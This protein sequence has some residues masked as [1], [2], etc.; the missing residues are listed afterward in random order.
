MWVILSERPLLVTAATESPPPM[1]EMAPLSATAWA[2]AK[3]PSANLG[4][5]N[6]PMGPFQ[7]TVPAPLRASQK[8]WTDFSPMSIPIQPSGIWSE[9]TVLELQSSANLS[10]ILL[11]TGSRKLTPLALAL[12]MISLASSTL[13]SSQMEVPME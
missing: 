9:G 5:S 13:S 1:M 10:P 11:S 2:T 4:I 6:T 8:S 3:V 12:S 7:M